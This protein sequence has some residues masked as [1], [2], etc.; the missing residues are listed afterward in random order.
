MPIAA[1]SLSQPLSDIAQGLGKSF[2]QYGFAIVRDHAI[3][4]A[5][6]EKAHRTAK[7]FFA[8]PE[9]AKRTYHIAGTG[10]ARGYTPF[11][12]EQAKDATI[13]DLKE[14]WHVGQELPAGHRLEAIMPP[15]VWPAEITEF[16]EAM[17]ALFSA[18]EEA[19]RRVL[20]AIA[21][22]LDLDE[23]FFDPTVTQGNS[24]MRLLHY[25]PVPSDA[26]GA[27]RA[28]AHE[29]INVITLLLG[30][31]E[32]GLELLTRDGEWLAVAPEEGEL[33]VNVA[34]MLER[35]TNGRL[36]S[37]THRVVNP[38]GEAARRA[39]YSMPFFLHFRPDYLIEPL[40][41]CK[42]DGQAAMPSITAHDYLQERLREIGLI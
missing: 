42:I 39:R 41:S 10:G 26:Q 14:F 17:L 23:K 29:D 16:R 19:G 32:S 25:P 18:F 4:A 34:D 20:S 36:R 27:I 11:R 35:L 15:N 3:D 13:Q 5:L 12:V 9:E 33:V 22:H 40:E 21:L 38:V 37:T 1:L 28:A 6:I 8:L 30:A 2:E 7:A 24:I 31:E